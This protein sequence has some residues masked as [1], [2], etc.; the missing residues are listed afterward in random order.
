MRDRRAVTGL[1]LAVTVLMTVLSI[2]K[3]APLELLES[4][5]LDAR[6]RLRPSL[7]HSDAVV[8]AAIDEKSIAR[9]GRWPWDRALLAR[10]VRQLDRSGAAVIVSD[11][12]L[13]EPEQNDPLLAEAMNE[14]GNV[15]LPVAFD[16]HRDSRSPAGE[17]LASSSIS[18]AG[19]ELF[20]ASSPIS[21]KGVL[22]PVRE[23]SRE[24]AGLGHI[25]IMPDDDGAVR[26]EIMAV[27]YNGGLYPSI[28][29]SAA[30]FYLGI[31]PERIVVEATKGVRLGDRY[32]PTDRWGR[33]LINYHAPAQTFRRISIVD[34]LDG[35]SDPKL[36]QDR[37]VLIG[38]TDAVGIHDLRATPLAPAAPGAEKH[39][40]VIASIIENKF[41][42]QTSLHLDAALILLSGLL[43]AL[44]LPRFRAAAAAGAA[45][46]LLAVLLAF[47]YYLFAYKGLWTPVAYPSLNVLLIFIGAVTWNYAAEERH[48][49]RIRALFS[50]YV[51]ERVVDELI[52]H[53]EAARVGG[54]RREVTVLFADLR[55]FTGFAEKRPPEEVVALLNEHFGV[56][57]N[58]VLKWEGTLDKF[59]GDALLAFWGAPLQQADHAERALRCALEMAAALEALREKW[60][61]EGK[62]PLACGIGMNT[63]EVVVGNIGAAERKMEYTVIGDHVNLASRVESLTGKYT[64][65]II[66]TEFT[67]AKVREALDEQRIAQVTVKGLD[68]V[69]VKGREQ[70]VTIYEVIHHEHGTPSRVIEY[71]QEFT[72]A[73]SV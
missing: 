11:V 66:I 37:I 35:A 3:P 51:A 59:V 40:S 57:T 16:F 14:A 69:I 15:L 33:T 13:S 62:P 72:G 2:L 31:P 12:L 18:V 1:A 23:L 25:T 19:R 43:L 5:L 7:V 42:Q 26:W 9:L 34:I 6:F 50:S 4:K 30:A 56:L 32:I 28:D 20:A 22:M 45:A 44:L 68:R 41:L 73:L 49:R 64:A 61:A 71:G 55:G 21:A 17:R 48:A 70:P 46:G 52:K 29:L 54:E 39:A 47:T 24:A 27:E 10:L 58:I 63:G 38:A 53:P 65:Q 36:L 67:L 60:R 8:I